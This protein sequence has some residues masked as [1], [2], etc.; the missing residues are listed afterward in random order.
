MDK[1][2]DIHEHRG[3][4][5]GLLRYHYTLLSAN[6]KDDFLHVKNNKFYW[7]EK[8]GF[9]FDDTYRHY[10]I[11]KTNG[12][13]ISIICDFERDLIF[14]LSLLNRFI[15]KYLTSQFSTK[16]LQKMCI[17]EKKRGIYIEKN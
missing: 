9:L 4:N 7:K 8:D 6:S 3:P 17:P 11:K 16:I 15:L 14:P 10:V 5:A 1:E 2:L 12:M 13:R